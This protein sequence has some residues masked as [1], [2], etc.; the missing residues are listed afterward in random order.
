MNYFKIVLVAVSMTLFSCQG[1]ESSKIE[2]LDAKSFS[3]KIKNNSDVQLLDVRTPDEYASQHIGNATN[4]NYNGA[5][6][7][8]KVAVFE[9]SKPVYV[10]CLSGGRSK[11]A[12]NKLAEMGY[13]KVYELEGGIMKWNAAGL[14]KPATETIGMTQDEY[15]KLLISP[16]EAGFITSSKLSPLAFSKVNLTR[17]PFV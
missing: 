3:E 9:K 12:A 13:T 16:P 6:F 10:Y 4:I 8:Q 17:L 5:D 7:E 11:Q 14:A 1:Q 15:N 2:K